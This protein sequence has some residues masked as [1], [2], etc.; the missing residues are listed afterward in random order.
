MI[1]RPRQRQRAALADPWLIR[2]LT[3]QERPRMRLFCFH[4]AGG[5]GTEFST[6]PPSLRGE[7]EVAP[8]QLP[9]VSAT[10]HQS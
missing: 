3:E 7:I 2:P 9:G 8:V 10:M 1:Q 6:W 4:C 5:A